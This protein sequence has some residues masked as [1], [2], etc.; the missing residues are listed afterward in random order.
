MKRKFYFG[1]LLL[2]V[3]SLGL[4]ACAGEVTPTPSLPVVAATATSTSA[5]TAT[6]APSTT[7]VAT[8]PTVTPQPATATTAAVST[9]AAPATTSAAPVTTS[10][11]PA[12][13]TA[14]PAATVAPATTATSGTVNNTR[15]AYV[16]NS[17][18][19]V[20]DVTSKAKKQL[21][22][23]GQAQGVYGDP[24]WAGDYKTL[25]VALQANVKQKNS[26]ATLYTVNP[27]SGESKKLLADQP[28]N[29]SDISPVFSPDGTS[30]AFTR[31]L[32]SGGNFDPSASKHEIWLVDA[33]GQNPRK[34]A[35][36]WQPAWS[37]DSRRLA[38]V[39]DGTPKQGTP[40]QN[41]ALH[42][43]NNKGQNEWEPINTAKVP[44]DWTK[45][46]FPFNGEAYVIQSPVFLEDGKTIGFTT[47]G[48]TGLALTMNSNTGGDLKLWA[49]QMEGGFGRAFAQPKGG[50]FLMFEN[51]PPSG[52]RGFSIAD[53][54][55]GAAP[56]K[57][58]FRTMGGT[59][60]RGEAL[61]PAW[62]PDG[63]QVAYVNS[64]SPSP[65]PAVIAP[66]I[67]TILKISSGETVEL[68]SGTISGVAWT[69]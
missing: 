2:L 60:N 35:N 47:N 64:K 22:P 3:L 7:T 68:A 48:A 31:V 10:A 15:V 24:A 65:D 45:F 46:N 8:P 44:T 6:T 13:T 27:D 66:G 41:N 30:I 42:L 25:V 51:Y 33:N 50:N 58:L 38:F 4:G 9:T 57:P 59:P 69:R 17:G 21:L 28:A 40:Y 55:K 34:L 54:S 37:P 5:A 11:A 67:L 23:G 1:L 53:L 20:I 56:D 32:G 63:T 12:T 36:G 52:F 29:T 18:L 19:F 62:S 61:F 43:I 39:T 16:D 26:A 14:I 49:G